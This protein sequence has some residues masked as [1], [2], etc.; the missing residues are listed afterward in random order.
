MVLCMACPYLGVA[1]LLS[2]VKE[3]GCQVV[4]MQRLFL[5]CAFGGRECKAGPVS[6]PRALCSSAR[7]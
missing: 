3:V 1:V 7:H 5:M 2:Q 4:L 6:L